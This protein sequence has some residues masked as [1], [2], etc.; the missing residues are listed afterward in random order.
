MTGWSGSGRILKYLWSYPSSVRL[1]PQGGKTSSLV[2]VNVNV[3]VKCACVRVCTKIHW[4][5]AFAAL[6]ILLFLMARKTLAFIV[7]TRHGVSLCVALTAHLAVTITSHHTV[8][9]K[10]IPQYKMQ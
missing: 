9:R 1:S 6:G 3:C 8:Q 10:Q 4:Q 5:H 7:R 2:T